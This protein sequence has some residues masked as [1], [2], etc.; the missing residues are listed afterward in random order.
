MNPL[1]LNRYDYNSN[2]PIMYNDP[3][4]HRMMAEDGGGATAYASSNAAINHNSDKADALMVQYSKTVARTQPLGKKSSAEIYDKAVK[5]LQAAKDGT[6]VSAQERLNKIRLNRCEGKVYLDSETTGVVKSIVK[7]TV[8]GTTDTIIG[9]TII[10]NLKE[11]KRGITSIPSLGPAMDLETVTVK[12]GVKALKGFSKYAGPA[13]TIGYGVEIYQDYKNYEGNNRIVAITL[14]SAGT[15]LS[16]AG[17]A[18]LVAASAPV[19]VV[20]AGGVAI[21]I[22]VGYGVD[23]AKD[24]LLKKKK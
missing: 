8:I 10:E 3:S 5:A 9:K 16:I 6:V 15:A 21:G 12:S 1:T 24:K 14:T 7:N 2:N 20:V 18:V 22:G 4:G 17:G 13:A 23:L 19:I 11:T